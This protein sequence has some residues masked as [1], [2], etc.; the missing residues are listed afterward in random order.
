MNFFYY[1]SNKISPRFL[2]QFNKIY[3][4]RIMS[5]IFTPY[6][7]FHSFNKFISSAGSSSSCGILSSPRL[8][9]PNM[10]G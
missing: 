7:L 3:N 5:P 9:P 6:V 4:T 1:L 2:L 8:G 10:N